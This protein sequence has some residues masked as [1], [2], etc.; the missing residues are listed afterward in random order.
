VSAVVEQ[1]LCHAISHDIHYQLQRMLRQMIDG[2]RIFAAP[3]REV[4]RGTLTE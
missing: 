3:S 2:G 1:V 4:R